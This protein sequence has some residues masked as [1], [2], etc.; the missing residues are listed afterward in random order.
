[1][2]QTPTVRVEPELYEQ[3]RNY[4]RLTGVPISSMVN[5]ALAAR[6][7]VWARDLYER[8]EIVLKRQAQHKKRGFVPT[9]TALEQELLD[10]FQPQKEPYE[11]GD[12]DSDGNP[13]MVLHLHNHEPVPKKWRR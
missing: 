7:D 11:E 12:L 10:R 1:M 9:L 2:T 13:R 4:S 6:L 3:M 8:R 5:D